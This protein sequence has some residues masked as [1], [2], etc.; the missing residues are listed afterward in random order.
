MAAEGGA[1][2][3]GHVDDHGVNGAA[4]GWPRKALIFARLALSTLRQWGRDRLAAEGRSLAAR[5][6]SRTA[7]MGPR[8]VGRGRANYVLIFDD[9][10]LRQWGRDRLAAEGISYFGA[11]L[12]RHLASMGPRPVGRGRDPVSL[13]L[14]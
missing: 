5:R 3:V 6:R 11:I 4:T 14:P 7:S 12:S 2:A 10:S 8:P 13:I 9:V 1:G